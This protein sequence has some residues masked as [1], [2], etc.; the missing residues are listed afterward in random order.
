M[1][2]TVE[3]RRQVDVNV[4]PAF[5][6]NLDLIN[7][8]GHPAAFVPNSFDEKGNPTSIAFSGRLS[9]E[10]ELLRAAKIHHKNQEGPPGRALLDVRI[11]IMP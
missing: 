9:G 8:T 10:A 2:E 4:A 5:G 6:E 1:R 7:L 11:Y 3:K